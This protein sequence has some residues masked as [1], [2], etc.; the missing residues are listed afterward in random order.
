MNDCA[1]INKALIVSHVV[2]SLSSLGTVTVIQ[3]RCNGMVVSRRALPQQSVTIEVDAVVAEN[4]PTFPPTMFPQLRSSYATYSPTR[5]PYW[6]VV[7]TTASPVGTGRRVAA[8][9]GDDDESSSL[10]WWMILLIVLGLCLSVVLVAL[11][12]WR[13]E[14]NGKKTSKQDPENSWSQNSQTSGQGQQAA[15][16]APQPTPR[17]NTVF[18]PPLPQQ[19]LTESQVPQYMDTKTA[20]PIPSQSRLSASDPS[21]EGLSSAPSI[22]DSRYL[23]DRAP[24]E[25]GQQ[26]QAQYVDGQWYDAVV[27]DRDPYDGKYTLNWSD[28]SVSSGV[29]REQIAPVVSSAA[30]SP[31]NYDDD[32]LVEAV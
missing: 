24:I 8:E 15:F 27:A 10:P 21:I 13:A 9:K 3:V 25:Y 17:P 6:P 7:Q 11:L 31:R 29:P 1:L 23:T 26:V 32:I 5:Y 20:A 19:Y 28:G 4:V 30:N 18:L 12:I 16:A 22:P 2:A 14:K